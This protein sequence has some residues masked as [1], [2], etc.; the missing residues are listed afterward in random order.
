MN[1]REYMTEET[2]ADGF[3]GV[4]ERALRSTQR[5][6][7]PAAPAAPVPAPSAAFRRS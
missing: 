1:F 6:P 3:H 5:A 4:R 7:P 2:A